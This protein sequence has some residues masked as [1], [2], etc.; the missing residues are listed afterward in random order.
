MLLLV[1]SR[2]L[3]LKTLELYLE[4]QKAVIFATSGIA[5]RVLFDDSLT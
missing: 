3:A 2:K 5:R 1:R 4:M